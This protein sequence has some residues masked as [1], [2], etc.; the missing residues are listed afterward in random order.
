MRWRAVVVC[1][2]GLVLLAAW[3]GVVRAGV[4]LSWFLDGRPSA[5]AA[6]ALGLLADSA[7][8]GLDPRDYGGPALAQQVAAA[9][10][11][12]PL[13]PQAQARLDQAL[14]R[15]LQRYLS[16]LYRGRVDPRQIHQD[17]A[18]AW[19]G[20][21]DAAAALQGALAADRLT[22]SAREL[23]P[24]L[25]MYARL[26]EALARYRALGD[27]AAWA[28]ALP[29]LPAVRARPPKLEPGGTWPGLALLAERLLAL[30]DLAERPA[31]L[32]PNEVARYEGPLVAAVQ[33][34]QLRHGL[35]PDGVLG[36]ATWAALQVTPAARVRQI[37]LGLE[38]LRW[39][40]LLQGPRMVVIN[41]PEFVL[42][43][44]EVGESGITVRTQ[45]KV[46]VGKML[47]TRTP[48]FDEDMRFIEFAPYWNVPPSIARGEVVP[49]LRRDP[50]Y[51]HREGFEFVTAA[52]EVQT[53]LSSAG[54]A[55]VLA[56]RARIRQRP[57]PA[58]ALGDIKFVFPNA[59]N[60][61]LHHTPAVSLFER[62]RRDFSHGCIRIEKP[63]EL[64]KFVLSDMPEWTETRIR[65]AMAQGKSSTLRLNE[66]VPVLITYG[67]TL[68]KEGRIF[69]FDDIYGHDRLLD[70]ALRAHSAGL[71]TREGARP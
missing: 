65:E 32:A 22:A 17:Y 21:F 39:T 55:A 67:T 60:I 26:R 25:P 4:P 7:S 64:A 9:S 50:A 29:P 23:W 14:T 3:P 10:Q 8:H 13:S 51:W 46:I 49:R 20:D 33:A 28:Q 40:P 57:G 2:W 37:E 44:Y 53:G 5:Q 15:A 68:V 69:F 1:V 27:H 24:R 30:G 62:D 38:R 43:A 47:D 35:A 36:R 41:I 16:D 31:A 11:G 34:F 48:L 71:D 52:G 59:S 19:P 45:M 18:V 42:R 61:Y 63:V 56:G 54:L 12:E 70:A 6:E 58:N 66:P